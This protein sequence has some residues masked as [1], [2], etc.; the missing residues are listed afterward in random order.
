MDENVQKYRKDEV[1]PTILVHVVVQLRVSSYLSNEPRERKNHDT[2]ECP[3]T[4]GNL[5][6]DLILEKFGMLH[7]VVIE[8]VFV[9]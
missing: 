9:G 8:D 1:W 6:A 2:R 7:H 5:Q 4:G 3:Q